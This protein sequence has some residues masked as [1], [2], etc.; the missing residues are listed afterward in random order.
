[1]ESLCDDLD[2]KVLLPS[3]SPFLKIAKHQDQFSVAFTGAGF[4]KQYSFP[5][6]DVEI[7]PMNNIT[8]ELLAKYVCEEAV[9]KISSITEGQLENVISI[10]VTIE[11]TKGQSV[12][13]VWEN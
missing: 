7:L 4:S 5:C 13:Y 11:E 10:S 2:E 8:S 6:E 12:S 1:M 3:N 9:K